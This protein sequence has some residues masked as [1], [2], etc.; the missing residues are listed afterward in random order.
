M[1]VRFSFQRGC[2]LVACAALAFNSISCSQSKT[3]RS[4]SP[5][6]SNQPSVTPSTLPAPSEVWMSGFQQVNGTPYFYAPIYV[7]KTEQK[8]VWQQ[9]KRGLQSS[10]SYESYDEYG[11]GKGREYDVDVRNY[12]FIHRDNL[13][14]SKL[15]PNNNARILEINEIGPKV[16]PD[17]SG[18]PVNRLLKVDA[19]WYVKVT[20]DTN[21]DK[22][23]NANDRKQIGISDPDGS[24]YVEVIKDIDRI[25][26]V[27]QKG[28]DRR[29][30]VYSVG[31]KRFAADVD[32][33]KRQVTTKELPA[34]D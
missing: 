18:Q 23:L 34:I 31:K 17:K 22:I 25:L 6:N 14:G 11:G 3:D 30:V 19:F 24:N 5:A 15:L 13:S 29:L 16:P 9:I 1:S 20:A 28:L 7:S 10:S 21:G 2:L 32:I 27:Q 8:N 33:T 4:A 12:M 26:L